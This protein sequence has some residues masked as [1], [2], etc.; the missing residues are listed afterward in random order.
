MR[1]RTILAA[2]A[3]LAVLTGACSRSGTSVP[4]SSSAGRSTTTA[5]AAAG[6]GDFGTLKAVCGPGAPKGAT[7][8]GV[9][10]TT[11][12]IG[13]MSDPGAAAAPGLNQELFDTAKAFTTWCNN[14]G[15]I[16]GR[17]ITL[18]LRD[19]KLFEVAARTVE[20]CGQDFMEVG[21]GTAF[22]DSGVDQRLK[23]KLP[24]IAAYDNSPK[25]T[26]AGLKVEVNPS[27]VEQEQVALYR[28]YQALH[29]GPVKQGLLVGNL[30]PIVVTK[31]RFKEATEKIG[32]TTVYDEIYPI[33]GI[34]NPQSYV[35]R[36]K[37]KG[38]EVLTEVG[39]PTAMVALEKAMQAVGWYPKA[40]IESANLYDQLLVKNGADAI[41]N[42]WV[43]DNYFPFE[44]AGTNP[45]T[46][47]F[48]DLMRANAPGG[49]IAALGRNAWDAW[50]LFATSA[51]DCGATLTRDCV[52]QKAGAHPDWTAGGLK[53]PVSTDPGV[54][55]MPQCYLAL[56]ASPQGFAIDPAFLVPNKGLFNCDPANVV[57]L[58]GN[59]APKS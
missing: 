30:A 19:A 15:G 55:Q 48:L 16:N 51:R 3:A 12:D 52:L 14:A 17:K 21:N 47:Q 5:A 7:D 9:T 53:S 20:A 23:C 36:M 56:K 44:A 11:I 22:D 46:Q 39:E 35:Q 18:H 50:L 29:P 2:A 43:V 40:I 49:K 45:A 57:K 10:D 59:Y 6:P 8:P 28:A 25:A 41:S 4:A 24:E 27:P 33:T 26:E 42:T 58:T 38:V 32:F 54:R 31:N 13:T 37:D 1:Q 34:D